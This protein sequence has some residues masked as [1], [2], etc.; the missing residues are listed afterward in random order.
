MN[1]VRKSSRAIATNTVTSRR[2][3]LSDF[4]KAVSSQS[5]LIFAF[6]SS[7]P[8]LD[9]A[10]GPLVLSQY[11]SLWCSPAPLLNA[12]E[13]PLTGSVHQSIWLKCTNFSTL[14]RN[15]YEKDCFHESFYHHNW[16]IRSWF[17]LLYSEGSS[18]RNKSIDDFKAEYAS[19]SSSLDGPRWSAFWV[20]ESVD[21]LQGT[22][23]ISNERFK[24]PVQSYLTLRYHNEKRRV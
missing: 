7:S 1:H 9:I 12:L 18:L 11:K 20:P 14:S 5:S 13:N 3:M 8:V 21:F 10:K 16:H 19:T 24:S 6:T 17:R 2:L 23:T 22:F 15:N 4:L